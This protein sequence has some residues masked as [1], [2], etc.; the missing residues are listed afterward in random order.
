MN[1]IE[2]K[3]QRYELYPPINSDSYL[4]GFSIIDKLNN[5][6]ST[7]VESTVFLT[8]ASGKTIDE[9]CQIAYQNIKPQIDKMVE[10]LKSKRS[11]IIGYTFLPNA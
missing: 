8:Q 7:Y 1:E 11:T 3:I 5:N 9:I 6:L 10:N 2:F 4:V